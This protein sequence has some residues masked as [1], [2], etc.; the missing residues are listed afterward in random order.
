[1]LSLGFTN[2]VHVEFREYRD[3]PG[4]QM[5]FFISCANT[6]PLNTLKEGDYIEIDNDKTRYKSVYDVL[7]TS[8]VRKV[9]SSNEIVSRNNNNIPSISRNESRGIISTLNEAID[10]DERNEYE[11]KVHVDSSGKYS[12][13]SLIGRRK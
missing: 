2:E 1:M 3:S 12:G 8:I 11:A 7:D 10:S 9:S 5:Q 13:F 4:A 6:Y